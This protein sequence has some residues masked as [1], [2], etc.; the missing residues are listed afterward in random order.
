[1]AWANAPAAAPMIEPDADYA[2]TVEQ[3]DDYQ[4]RRKYWYQLR[5]GDCLIPLLALAPHHPL[6][7]G[8]PIEPQTP[9]SSSSSRR[10]TSADGSTGTPSSP[11]SQGTQ[12]DS[13]LAPSSPDVTG[14]PENTV[15]MPPP[16]SEPPPDRQRCGKS[17]LTMPSAAILVCIDTCMRPVD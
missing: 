12:H 4:S 1:M 11:S 3:E 8:G 6:L 10:P 5:P 2:S 7:N 14:R 9:S 13:R 15:A 17:L 16:A